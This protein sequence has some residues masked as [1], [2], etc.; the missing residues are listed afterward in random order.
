MVEG[1]GCFN[2]I[3]FHSRGREKLYLVRLQNPWGT[4]EWTGPFSDTCVLINYELLHDTSRT[5]LSPYFLQ[6]SISFLHPQLLNLQVLIIY[7]RF[8]LHA[9]SLSSFSGGLSMGRELSGR[10]FLYTCLSLTRLL[11]RSPE[12][13]NISESQ[14]EKL[15]LTFSDDGEFW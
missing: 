4:K 10:D 2:Q 6:L 8:R 1:I 15:G 5:F 3:S 13:A 9:I 14:R 12:W 11:S 7:S